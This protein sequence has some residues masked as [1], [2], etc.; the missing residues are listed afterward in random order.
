[1]KQLNPMTRKPL[2]SHST[3]SE[4]QGNPQNSMRASRLD[5][6]GL[7]D[8]VIAASDENRRKRD[9]FVHFCMFR[10]VSEELKLVLFD[11]TVCSGL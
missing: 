10:I 5:Q 7:G 3:V 1:M 9:L 8:V 4:S 2:N 6:R 11:S